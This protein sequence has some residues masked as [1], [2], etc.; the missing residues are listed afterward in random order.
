MINTVLINYDQIYSK[1]ESILAKVNARILIIFEENEDFD[2]LFQIFTTLV[3]V[4]YETMELGSN[5][6]YENNISLIS[7]F[8]NVIYWI[9]IEIYPCERSK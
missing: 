5:L 9:I 3:E 6:F 4:C 7:Y 8:L 2:C 1:N